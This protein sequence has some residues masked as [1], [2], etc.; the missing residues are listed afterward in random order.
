MWGRQARNPNLVHSNKNGTTCANLWWNR[1]RV[2]SMDPR[3]CWFQKT[4][5]Q[6]KMMIMMTTM[7]ILLLLSLE[8]QHRSKLFPSS[9]CSFHAIASGEESVLQQLLWRLET[10]SVG[11]VVAA[12]AAAACNRSRHKWLKRQQ[13]VKV[14]EL[15]RIVVILL[16]LSQ[17]VQPF[18][19]RAKTDPVKRERERERS[20]K[21]SAKSTQ[22]CTREAYATKEGLKR[23]PEGQI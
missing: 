20:W 23:N 19:T 18:P 1:W 14:S 13:L 16:Q 9:C 6:Q 2:R 5:S 21:P 4:A 3:C 12:A 11:V 22:Q 15:L 10:N 17:K 8:Q 7:M